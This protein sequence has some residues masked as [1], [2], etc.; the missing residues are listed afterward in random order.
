[1]D[2]PVE[3][4]ASPIYRNVRARYARLAEI[5][6]GC[7]RSRSRTASEAEVAETYEE[8]RDLALELAKE[9][10]Q[11]SRFKGLGEMNS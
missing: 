7:R 3:L 1:M 5:V 8:L 6:G 2:V 9:G 10:I 11:L 4:L